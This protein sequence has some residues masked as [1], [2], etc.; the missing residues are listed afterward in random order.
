MMCP[1]LSALPVDDASFADHYGYGCEAWAE[2]TLR[3]G[4][5]DCHVNDTDYWVVEMGWYS[6]ENMLE[7]QAACPASCAGADVCNDL[8]IEDIPAAYLKNCDDL[9]ASEFLV[10]INS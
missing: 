6:E 9:L 2:D 8:P 5:P 1:D 7:I 4:V 3:S 10:Q